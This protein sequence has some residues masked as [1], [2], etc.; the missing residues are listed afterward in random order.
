M[1][2]LAIATQ[3]PKELCDT[4]V[5]KYKFKLKGTGPISFHLGCDF[6]QDKDGVLCMAPK[7]YIEKMVKAYERLF[8]EKPKQNY[9][10]PLEKNDHPEL[11]TSDLLDTDGIKKY[12]SL[13]GAM[14]WAVSLGRLDITTAVMTMSGFRVAPRK[15]HLERLKRIY[16]YLLRFKEAT[17][18]FVM[19]EPDLSALPVQHYNWM[20]TVYGDV[21]ELIPQDIPEL[22]GNL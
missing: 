5:K 13:I 11:D 6:F 18:R 9:T 3:N 1:D 22:L 20:Y 15:G 7:K 12:Q 17:I 10:S 2:D 4:L 21:K 19:E 14:Q 8:G 16:G